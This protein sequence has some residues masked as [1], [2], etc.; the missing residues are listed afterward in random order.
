MDKPQSG[1][2]FKMMSLMFKFRD[3]IRPRGN[4]LREVGLKPGDR[5]L[6]FGCG[7]GGYI[8]AT[9]RLIGKSGEIY[10]LDINPQA[11]ESVRKLAT[12]KKLGNV[13]TI[14]SDCATGLTGATMDA[15]LLYDVLH[16]LKKLD[17]VL[18]ELYRVLKPEGVLSVTDHHLT[19]AEIAARIT[20]TGR[21]RLL[22][23]SKRV[24][25]FS[26]V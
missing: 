2:S 5:V 18:S 16:H 14:V 19:E 4:I 20:G 21:F 6:D 13:E 1:L 11:I 23:E 7:P 10:A 24:Y 3:L 12:K 26:K 8:P 25:N 15:V 22:P 9:A 17:D